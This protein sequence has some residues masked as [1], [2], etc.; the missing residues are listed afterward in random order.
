MVTV[1]AWNAMFFSVTL[2]VEA[3]WGR[4][5]PLAAGATPAARTTAGG[6]G[7]GAP[8]PRGGGGGTPARGD[9][10]GD[11]ECGTRH[12]LAYP[13]MKRVAP[14]ALRIWPWALATSNP[15]LGVIPTPPS[16]YGV[17]SDSVAIA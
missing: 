6:G 17:L 13:L 5:P 14:P 8:P 16:P 11:G 1:A 15:P 3:G 2:A 10:G 9:A 4:P 12:V 7:G